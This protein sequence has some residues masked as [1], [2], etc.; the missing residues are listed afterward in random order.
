M[1]THQDR[2]KESK[3]Q[4]LNK[5][6]QLS[7]KRCCSH[8]YMN[9]VNLV[10]LVSF[11]KVYIHILGIIIIRDMKTG[12]AARRFRF[13]CSTTIIKF[14]SIGRIIRSKFIIPSKK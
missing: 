6:K 13:L 14:G 10:L 1:K 7:I 9:N 3:L 8:I 5:P 12:G 11:Q 4:P 2:P